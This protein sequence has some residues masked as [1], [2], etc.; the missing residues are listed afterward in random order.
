[1]LKTKGVKLAWEEIT[2]LV[3][4]VRGQPLPVFTVQGCYT[5][6]GDYLITA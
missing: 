6:E 5:P 1:M 3:V 2:H 4:L